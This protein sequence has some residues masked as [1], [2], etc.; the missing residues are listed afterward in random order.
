MLPSDP[1]LPLV[2]EF[3][4]ASQTPFLSRPAFPSVARQELRARLLQEEL[5]EYIEALREGNLTKVLDALADL[6]Y[7]LTGTVL[8]FGMGTVFVPAFRE[9]QR[10]NMS[11]FCITDQ[12]VTDTIE[13]YR[14][15]GI[16]TKSVTTGNQ[17]VI[18]RTEDEKILKSV[19]YSPAELAK[20]VQSDN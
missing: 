14:S 13:S 7:I 6:Q 11:K 17:T 5:D 18:L 3:Y 19:Q 8:E 2:T 16:E 1:Y 10:S 15:K 4:Q 9:V 12:E 20:F